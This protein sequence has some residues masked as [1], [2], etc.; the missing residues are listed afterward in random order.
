MGARPS[1]APAPARDPLDRLV[2]GLLFPGFDGHRAPDW[3]RRWAGEGLGGVVLF[4][5][6]VA[7]PTQL[8]DLTRDLHAQRED[9]LVAVDEEGGDVT[10]LHARSGSPYPGHATLGQADDTQSTRLV[11][12]GIGAELRAAGVAWDFAPDAD[13]NDDAANPVIG[14]RSFGADPD[15][16]GRHVAAFV[17][18]L[19]QDAGVA[20]CPKHFPGHGHTDVD[21]HVGLPV[22]RRDRAG[23]EAV[24]LAP[25]RAALAAGARTVMV[26][27]LLVPALDPRGPASTSRRVVEGLLREELGFGGVVVCDA[28]EMGGITATMELAEGAVRALSAGVDALCLGG[29]LADERVVREVHAAV[30]RAVREGR[31]PEQRLVQARQRL[32]DLVAWC[33]DAGTRPGLS[34][35]EVAAD[36]RR[37]GEAAADAAAHTFGDAAIG[38]G[39]AYVITLD[40]QPSVAAGVVPWG[41]QSQLEAARPGTTGVRVGAGQPVDVAVR[42]ASGRPVVLV[43]RDPHRQPWQMIAAREVLAVRPDAV[44]V[45]MG[46]PVGAL[47]GLAR[48]SVETF[49]ASAVNGDAAV[50]RLC[51]PRTTGDR[52]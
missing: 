41:V 11:A 18:G 26:G 35:G 52:P 34:V 38:S 1:G 47:R 30:R 23:L 5:R 48:G 6:N 25:F 36:A 51:R 8:V 24:D 9:L 39:P 31:L 44:V 10:R 49:G 2:S 7:G 28:L 37:A 3:V 45:D 16:V 43:V 14:V 17:A 22:V 42:A 50:R 4:G 27:H 29:E 32:D 40:A 21:S 12:A 20:A 13:V 15:N 33:R 46:W 19:Q